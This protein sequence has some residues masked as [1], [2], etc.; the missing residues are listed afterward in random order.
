MCLCGTSRRS[1]SQP[2]NTTVAGNQEGSASPGCSRVTHSDSDY[3]GTGSVQETPPIRCWGT[4]EYSDCAGWTL[5]VTKCRQARGRPP[6]A[7]S[8]SPGALLLGS[9]EPPFPHASVRMACRVPAA[10]GD[11]L[12][13]PEQAVHVRCRP[14]AVAWDAGMAVQEWLLQN[15]PSLEQPALSLAG[16]SPGREGAASPHDSRASPAGS[17]SAC[18][19]APSRWATGGGARSRLFLPPPSQQGRGPAFRVWACPQRCHQCAALPQ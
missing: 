4:L 12:P 7:G 9:A 11:G 10:L 3:E 18:W 2:P 5:C 15:P 1:W 6:W 19:A 8:S 13:Q 14:P 17:D 16:A